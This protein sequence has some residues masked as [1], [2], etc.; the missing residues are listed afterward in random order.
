M[1]IEEVYKQTT[2]KLPYLFFRGKGFYPLEL[3]SNEEAIANAEC[4]PGTTMVQNAITL[5]VVWKL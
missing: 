4:N 3:D 5:E 2:G 1:T